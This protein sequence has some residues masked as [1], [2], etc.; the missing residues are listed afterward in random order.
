[1]VGSIP[2]TDVGGA[3]SVCANVG[4]PVGVLPAGMVAV[5]VG[6]VVG[7]LGLA[8]GFVKF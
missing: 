5:A 6:V 2:I 8:N 3:S 4:M 7:V 1:M